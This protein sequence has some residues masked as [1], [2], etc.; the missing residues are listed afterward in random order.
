MIKGIP[1]YVFES[2]MSDYRNYRM[3]DNGH[4]HT[5]A[6]EYLR[7][8]YSDCANE[9]RVMKLHQLVNLLDKKG[10]VISEEEWNG[11]EPK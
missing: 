2:V 10:N 3:S 11:E 6:I 5:E 1:D 8:Y 9:E 7:V 4:T